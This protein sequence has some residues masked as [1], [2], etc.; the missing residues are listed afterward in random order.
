MQITWFPPEGLLS[1]TVSQDHTYSHPHDVGGEP[2]GEIDTRDQG[3][4]H[5]EKYANAFRMVMTG[6]GLAS[7]DECAG[8]LED[9][10]TRFYKIGYFERQTEAA[11]IALIERGVFTQSEFDGEWRRRGAGFDVPALNL[12]SDHDHGKPIQEDDAG[13]PPNEHHIMNLPCRPF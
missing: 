10:G 8:R 5:W 1:M 6:K 13:G 9:L 2:S 12:P 7:L 11:A 3:M 4:T